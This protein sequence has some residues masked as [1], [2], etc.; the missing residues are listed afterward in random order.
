MFQHIHTFWNTKRNALNKA[1][2]R[3]L[4]SWPKEWQRKVFVHLGNCSSISADKS[5]KHF[6]HIRFIKII[7]YLSWLLCRCLVNNSL[8]FIFTFTQLQSDTGRMRVRPFPS[9]R[10]LSTTFPRMPCPLFA[11]LSLTMHSGSCSLHRPC[12][13]V[14]WRLDEHYTWG[15]LQREVHHRHEN[16]GQVILLFLLFIQRH[17]CMWK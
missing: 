4:P 17:M 9:S 8:A 10:T 3:S 15:S 16:R 5:S 7:Y 2:A 11:L 6:P 1:K 12:Q 13:V 14:A